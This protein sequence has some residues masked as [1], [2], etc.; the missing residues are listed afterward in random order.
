MLDPRT[1]TTA[2][3]FATPGAA[4]RT[5]SPLR[6]VNAVYRPPG[7]HWVGDG[8][9]VHGYFN[10]I[11]EAARRL[12]PFLLLD[13][14]PAYDYEPTDSPRGVGVHP[15]RGFE[16]VT[17]AFQGSV[18]HHDSA[19]NGGVI[20]PGDVQ[21]MTAASGILHK[22]YHEAE[23]ARRGGTFQMAQLWVNLPR[24]HKMDAPRYQGLTSAEMGEVNLPDGAG[25]VRVVAGQ[26]QDARGPAKTF[27]PIEL[28]HIKL[29][30]GRSLEVPLPQSYNVAL[31]IMDG[32]LAFS[33]ATSAQKHDFVIFKHD[34]DALR[35]TA[36]ADAEWLVMSGEPIDEPV[37]QYGPFVM[38]TPQEIQQAFVD[39]NQGKF[40]SLV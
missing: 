4:E 36:Q 14:H 32:T 7:L 20:G 18:A 10:T 22:E 23:F 11:P 17:I 13:Y 2:T 38:N 27:S 33:D 15:H 6:S 21:W 31:L 8:F 35:V 24:A 26:F 30:A 28:Y 3:N 9:R 19:G 5:S 29:K 39:Y 40:G 12:S 37:V 25:Q 34:G 1:T 16:T